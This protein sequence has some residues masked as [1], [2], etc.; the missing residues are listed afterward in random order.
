MAD[1]HWTEPLPIYAWL[2]EHDDGPI[3]VDTGETARATER[4]YFP[5]WH[6]YYRLAVRF[7]VRPEDELGPQLERLGVGVRDIRSV[8]MTHLHTDHAG[9]LH[10][11]RDREILV[12]RQE[13]SDTEGFAGKVGGYLR[14]RWPADANLT[15]IDLEERAYGPFERS[16]ELAGGVHL[17]A[18][19]GHT[20][21][22]MSVV[23]DGDRPTVL[24]GDVSYTEELMLQGATDGVSPNPRQAADTIRRMKQFVTE[25]NATY[26]PSH[27]PGGAA[28]LPTIT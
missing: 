25:S 3:L 15:P 17:V 24:A 6:P 18:T 28:R 5:R 19:P 21:G 16:V 22:H 14:D 4:G 11:V 26:L 7:D 9:G 8:V 23:V 12:T 13:L 2:V 20:P 10:H 27:D 1:R